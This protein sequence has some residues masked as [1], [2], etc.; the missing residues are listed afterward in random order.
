MREDRSNI[1][2]PTHK[3]CIDPISDLIYNKEDVMEVLTNLKLFSAHGP[4]GIPT[5][6]LL[7]Y[8]VYLAGG[9]LIL[10]KKEKNVT[11]PITGKFL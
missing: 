5:K 6:L 2:N 3:P 1:P 7:V 10:K 9:K 8:V 11:H 4:D